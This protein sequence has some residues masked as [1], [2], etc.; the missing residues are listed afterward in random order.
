MKIL[1]EPKVG[2]TFDDREIRAIKRVLNSGDNLT[3]GKDVDLFEKEFAKSCGAKY[4][5]SMSSCGAALNIATKY[6]GK[7][8][9]I[10][11]VEKAEFPQS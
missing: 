2:S 4:A 11:L 3:R 10:I 9:T 8:A 7:I 1:T 6:G 5:V